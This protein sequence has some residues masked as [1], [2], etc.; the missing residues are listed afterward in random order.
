MA[1]LWGMIGWEG[2]REG[3]GL[4]MSRDFF[5]GRSRAFALKEPF[6]NLFLHIWIAFNVVASTSSV[7]AV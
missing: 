1:C 3:G 2:E 6:S 7:S 4:E 5:G